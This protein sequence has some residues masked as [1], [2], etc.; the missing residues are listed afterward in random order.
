MSDAGTPVD[1]APGLTLDVFRGDTLS[2]ARRWADLHPRERRRRAVVAA[3]VL[4]AGELWSLTE[5]HTY[6]YGRAGGHCH[7]APLA[8]TVRVSRSS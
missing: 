1:T 7:P 2:G 6:L 3:Q 5:A 4:D 8:L